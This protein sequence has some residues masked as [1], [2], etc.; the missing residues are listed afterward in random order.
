MTITRTNSFG[1]TS[2]NSS[3]NSSWKPQE[4]PLEISQ[5]I[6]SGILLVVSVRHPLGI[7]I[8]IPLETTTK[9]ALGTILRNPLVISP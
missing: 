7:P 3:V 8:E 2:A 9:I 1:Y 5:R 4:I 6:P